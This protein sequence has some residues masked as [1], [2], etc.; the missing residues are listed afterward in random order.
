MLEDTWPKELEKVRLEKGDEEA[1]KLR[2]SLIL[3]L[4]TNVVNGFV[5]SE[6]DRQEIKTLEKKIDDRTEYRS[7]AFD[8]LESLEAS[9]DRTNPDDLFDESLELHDVALKF[10]EQHPDAWLI[11]KTQPLRFRDS[12][13][14][15]FVAY[16][17]TKV[18]ERK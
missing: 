7:S 18:K 17:R 5:E 8:T 14:E 6:L 11:R 12:I 13:N 9:F 15:F 1:K 2:N 16:V 4:M 10:L 3:F